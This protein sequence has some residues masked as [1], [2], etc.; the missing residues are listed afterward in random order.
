MDM[1]L[2]KLWE[3][4]KDREAWRAA[5]HGV[6]KIGHDLET[7]QQAFSPVPDISKVLAIIIS[8]FMNLI[9]V[10]YCWKDEMEFQIYWWIGRVEKYCGTQRLQ[11]FNG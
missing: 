9:V 8:Y 7:E 6:T 1:S 10:I 2:S 3:I 11:I 5:V 4:V